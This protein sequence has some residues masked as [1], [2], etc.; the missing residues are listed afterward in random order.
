MVQTDALSVT[1][2]PA[3]AQ[4]WRDLVAKTLGDK[5]MESL[6]SQTV[7]GLAI[8]P[9]YETGPW[10]PAPTRPFDAERDGF[11]IAEAAG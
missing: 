7:E 1:F 9:L 10:P 4:D 6:A 5:P 3:S 11:A 2:A 8:A